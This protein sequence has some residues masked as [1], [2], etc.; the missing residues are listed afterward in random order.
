MS[1]TR[2]RRLAYNRV[3]LCYGLALHHAEEPER[4]EEYWKSECIYVECLNEQILA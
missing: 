2:N 3:W 4:R 1:Y